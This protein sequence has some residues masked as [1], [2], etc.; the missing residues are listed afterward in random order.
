MGSNIGRAEGETG[1][2]GRG[3]IPEEGGSGGRTE[4]E[5]AEGGPGGETEED[6]SIQTAETVAYITE[7]NPTYV[8]VFDKDAAE[9]EE[10]QPTAQ[11]VIDGAGLESMDAYQN[12]H[13]VYLDDSVWYSAEGGLRSTIEQLDMLLALFDLA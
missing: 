11:E 12:N 10:G 13:I 9:R 7:K 5:A 2:G 6:T 4:G 3:G 8:F 1:E